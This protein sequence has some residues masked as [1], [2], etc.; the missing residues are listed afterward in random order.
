LNDD[1]IVFLAELLIEDP[2]P[3]VATKQYEARNGSPQCSIINLIIEIPGAPVS[4]RSSRY[5][6]INKGKNNEE[7]KATQ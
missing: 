4:R 3:H 1:Q 7:D 5:K 2:N 6:G